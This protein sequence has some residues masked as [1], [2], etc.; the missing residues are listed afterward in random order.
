M[1]KEQTRRAE[2]HR[3]GPRCLGE[4]TVAEYLLFFFTPSSSSPASSFRDLCC[5]S[6]LLD[7]LWRKV[8][9]LLSFRT[10]GKFPALS[11]TTSGPNHTPITSTWCGVQ[12]AA[13]L[14]TRRA[15][16]MAIFTDFFAGHFETPFFHHQSKHDEDDENCD[17][18]RAGG[19]AAS[20]W[21]SQFDRRNRNDFFIFCLQK[22]VEMRC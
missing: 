10:S 16:F 1:G 17:D 2:P 22:F 18:D 5:C 6:C 14:A 21:D 4:E 15:E 8:L 9:L 11:R 7:F 19:R 20:L 3:R 13:T 12:L